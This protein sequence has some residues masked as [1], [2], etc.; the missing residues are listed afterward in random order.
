MRATKIIAGVAMVS[1]A[2]LFIYT[3]RRLQKINRMR[4]EASKRVA[5]HGYETAHDI[6]YPQRSKR[7]GKYGQVLSY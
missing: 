6:L 7:P 1:A 4:D 5:E 2:A 3:V